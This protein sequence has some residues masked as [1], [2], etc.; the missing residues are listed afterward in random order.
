M[1]ITGRNAGST[2]TESSWSE[3]ALALQN[4]QKQHANSPEVFLLVWL[5]L[6]T[7]SATGDLV[8]EPPVPSST[9]QPGN[10]CWRG[11]ALPSFLLRTHIW[12]WV[13]RGFWLRFGHSGLAGVRE[14]SSGWPWWHPCAPEFLSSPTLQ[15]M[16]GSHL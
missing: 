14:L 10:N 2:L 15:S 1:L 9:E 13:S 7:S 5:L 6:T 16:R 8:P 3:Q 12:L 11:S 4:H